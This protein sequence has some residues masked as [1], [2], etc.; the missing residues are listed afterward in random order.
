MA[1]EHAILVSLEE[2]PGTGYE[3]AR[4]F[5][6]SIGFFWAAT[7]QQIYRTLK[8]MVGLGWVTGEEIAQDGRPDKRLYRVAD[9]GRVEVARWLAE[10]GE[11]TTLRHELSV[12]VRGAS[13]GDVAAVTAEVA[14]HRDVHAQRLDAF[15][16]IE[17][18]DFPDPTALAGQRLH[19]YLVLRGGVRAERALVEW[20]DEVLAA[21][22]E[23]DRR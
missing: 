7:H 12:K 16:A 13:L 18:R 22:R 17:R 15:L 19:Q 8:R 1:L 9:A 5:G 4:R 11:P 23:D 6:K 21:M 14:R 2:R 3:L 10:A 20:C